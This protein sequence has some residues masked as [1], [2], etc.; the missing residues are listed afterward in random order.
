MSTLLVALVGGDVDG[1]EAAL[2]FVH[3]QTRVGHQQPHELEAP[4][5]TRQEE[6]GH[7]AL[8]RGAKGGKVGK[9]LNSRKDQR[10]RGV[11]PLCRGGQRGV[12]WGVRESQ[13]EEESKEEGGHASS[14]CNVRVPWTNL[15]PVRSTG[16]EG[17]YRSS[18][19]VPVWRGCRGGRGAHV[20]GAVDVCEGMLQQMPHI[21]V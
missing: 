20:G 1:A 19:D 2:T 14:V 13:F 9:S 10:K 12:L 11:T 3:V 21:G 5:L 4:P 15:S 16:V 6:G 18:L 17:I 8:Q 7:A